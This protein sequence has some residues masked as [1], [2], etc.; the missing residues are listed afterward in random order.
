MV[1]VLMSVYYYNFKYLFFNLDL[2]ISQF[3]FTFSN[4]RSKKRS[5]FKNQAV[6][7]TRDL[8]VRTVSD[9]TIVS[10]DTHI[11]L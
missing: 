7:A 5:L 1:F 4:W 3:S 8:A 11:I 10:I 6:F 2:A 9:V